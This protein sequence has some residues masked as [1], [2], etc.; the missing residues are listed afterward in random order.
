VRFEKLLIGCT[1][2][3]MLIGGSIT[4]AAS[5]QSQGFKDVDSSFWGYS[6]ITWGVQ[7]KITSG[8]EDNTFKPGKTV[9]E[10]EF[11]TL[12]VQA[13]GGAEVGDKEKRWS[14]P[15][16]RVATGKNLPVSDN[17]TSTV[18]RQSVADIIVGTQGVHFVGDNAVQYM[19]A[20]G[21]TKGKTAATIE[22]Y[23]GKDTLTRAE[24]VAFIK[25]VIDKV[26]NKILIARPETPTPV[27]QLPSLVTTTEAIKPTDE[28]LPVAPSVSKKLPIVSI[29]ASFNQAAKELGLPEE[30][31][32]VQE[33]FVAN[34]SSQT[35]RIFDYYAKSSV[36]GTLLDTF[37]F[38]VFYDS[39]TGNFQSVNGTVNSDLANKFIQCMLVAIYQDSEKGKQAFTMNKIAEIIQ[40]I[41]TDKSSVVDMEL[42][43]GFYLRYSVMEENSEILTAKDFFSIHIK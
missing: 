25:N 36:D 9:T 14:D 38:S 13:F 43:D 2:A 19:L 6:A 42:A 35:N 1:I 21:L 31:W 40:Q 22:G 11:I 33:T 24:A 27:S 30:Q 3:S 4:S 37:A 39:R 7:Q 34:T 8:Y 18:T 32:L 10:E 41:H 16:Y 26:E 20:K 15:Y 23:K 5:V 29:I 17:R 12:L 28:Q